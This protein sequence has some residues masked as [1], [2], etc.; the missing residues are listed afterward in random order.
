MKEFEDNDKSFVEKYRNRPY[1]DLEKDYCEFEKTVWKVSGKTNRRSRA[2]IKL[3]S[4][5]KKDFY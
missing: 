1:R 5:E 4:R 2:I 3:T